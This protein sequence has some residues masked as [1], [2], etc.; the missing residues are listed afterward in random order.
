M[1]FEVSHLGAEKCVTGSCH[2]VRANGLNILVDCGSMQGADHALPME[3]WPVK[4]SEIDFVFVTHAHIDHIGRIPELI[5]KG[6]KGE[7]ITTHPTKK[8]LLPMLK[9]AMALSG[10]NE[11]EASSVARA[12]DELSWGFEYGEAFDLKKGIR[13]TFYRAGHILGSAFLLLESDSP[14]RS[15][16]F[17]GDLGCRNTPLLPDPDPP[18]ACDLLVL[19]STYGDRLHESREHRVEQL[20]TVLTRALSDG[21][22]VFIPAFALGRTQELLYELDRLYSDRSFRKEFPQLT[23]GSRIPVVLDSPLGLKLTEITSSLSGYWDREAKAL[24]SSGDHPMDFD[25]LYTASNHKD[26]LRLVEDAGPMLVLA[27]S[28]MCTGGR[29]VD[30]LKAGIGDPR[31]DIVFVGYNARGTP[32]REIQECASTAGG[33]VTLDGQRYRVKAGVHTLAGYSAHADQKE[34]IEWLQLMPGMPRRIELVHGEA[35]A[36][37]ALANELNRR[38]YQNVQ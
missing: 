36:R 38:G 29:I 5:R 10:L 9:D 4:A 30:H 1:S 32:G 27:G 6:F 28:G 17:S 34:L 18:P 26:H 8:L 33:H 14:R 7:I 12:T 21:G 16:L 25:R 13:F 35:P 20:G 23:E 2:L 24:L 19:E 15:V 22:K 37:E 3:G 31:N 11:E